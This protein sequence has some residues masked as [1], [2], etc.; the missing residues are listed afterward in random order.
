MAE[1][2]GG[3]SGVV[4]WWSVAHYGGARLPNDRS[5][6]R[7]EFGEVVRRNLATRMRPPSRG[8][9]SSNARLG[10]ESSDLRVL[11][12]SVLDTTGGYYR[13]GGRHMQGHGSTDQSVK[14]TLGSAGFKFF[15]QGSRSFESLAPP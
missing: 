3:A 13:A 4:E 14:Y 12:A 7:G 9:A 11:N 8:P 2:S 1:W 10:V 15:V 5:D 6:V